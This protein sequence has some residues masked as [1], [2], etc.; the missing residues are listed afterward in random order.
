MVIALLCASLLPTVHCFH[1]RAFANTNNLAVVWRRTQ[2]VTFFGHHGPDT[3]DNKLKD[4]KSF[5][6]DATHLSLSA[7]RE[8]LLV[9]ASL[10]IASHPSLASAAASPDVSL[11]YIVRP[12][13]DVF[14]D[15][16]SF[17]FIIRTILSWYP[18]TDITKFPYSVAVWPTEPLLVPVRELVPTQFGV[19]ISAI[20]WIMLLGL[21]REL[22]TGQQGI[23]SLM[24]RSAV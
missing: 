12:A 17:L 16:M 18:K 14:V 3:D 22:I 10:L 4:F 8:C 7:P 23:L 9:A 6:N 11:V 19:D 15:F 13:L 24:E 21:V 2:T 5:D 1:F 20:V